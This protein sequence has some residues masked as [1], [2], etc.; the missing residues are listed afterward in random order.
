MR[1]KAEAKQKKGRERRMSDAQQ[2][3]SGALRPHQSFKI[4]W[5]PKKPIER[6]RFCKQITLKQEQALLA[7]PLHVMKFRFTMEFGT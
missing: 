7:A 2:A 4:L 6:W 1:E 5:E 3:S